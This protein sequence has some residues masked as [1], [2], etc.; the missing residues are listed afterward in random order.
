MIGCKRSGVIPAKGGHPFA[1]GLEGPVVPLFSIDN[2][3]DSKQ[4]MC[5]VCAK[6]C[7]TAA[8]LELHSNWHKM[9]DRRYNQ[10]LK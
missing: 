7:N 6:R 2:E 8:R 5:S 9:E 1:D 10:L 4:F 3:T